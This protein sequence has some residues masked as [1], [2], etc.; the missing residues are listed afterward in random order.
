M[1]RTRT[2][3]NSG[4]TTA[5][6]HQLKIARDTLRM[7]R[8]MAGVMGGMTKAQAREVFTRLMAKARGSAKRNGPKDI[9]PEFRRHTLRSSS[10]RKV[11]SKRMA[12][13]ILLS[14]LRR[15]GKIPPRQQN[16]KGSRYVLRHDPRRKW[17]IFD[18]RTKGVAAYNMTQNQGVALLARM[19]RG[20]G[21][22]PKK[23]WHKAMG[24]IGSAKS[25]K[26]WLKAMGSLP[27]RKT[28]KRKRNDDSKFVHQA[29]KEIAPGKKFE[30][31]T[32]FERSTVLQRA[33]QLKMETAA[34]LRRNGKKKNARAKAKR[35]TK[36]K[37]NYQ[38]AGELYEKFHGRK[39]GR[40]SDTGLPIADYGSHAELGQLGKLV[41]LT[42]G[43]KDAEKP[44]CKKI[45]WGG[46]EAPDLAAE[47]GGR[48]LYLVG[49]N[50]S[51][52]GSLES[53]PISTD[54]DMI[55]LGFAYQ[56]EYF[57]RKAFDNHQ[58]V[59]YYHDLGEESGESPRAVYDRG[60]KRIHLVGGAYV[61]KPEGIVN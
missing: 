55:D 39:P 11:R 13:A 49:G 42:I 2:R 3:K 18:T 25:A 29:M 35:R 14:E 5:E 32:P 12:K 31:L 9:M 1:K 37:R 33:Q 60:K 27:G 7:P 50:Q 20:L 28:P 21:K 43:D 19:R 40:T 52:N 56:I 10:G 46:P 53:L 17:F 61:V 58:P 4:L 44:W 30:Q 41:S 51:L 15:A 59:T 57:T 22:N 47:P 34:G 6:R 38:D 45:T 24:K 23:S 54:K 36:R 48:Q 8:A 26:D 16:L